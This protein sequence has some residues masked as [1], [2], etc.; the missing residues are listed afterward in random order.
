[1]NNIIIG[2]AGH[3]DHGKSSLIRALTGVETDRLAEEKK[4]GITI[5]LGFAWLDLP[6]GGRA[7]IIDVPGHERFISNMLAGAG[8]M[9]LAL[10]IVAADEGVMPQ[11]REHLEILSLLGVPQGIIVINKADLVDSEWLELVSE[12][13]RENCVGTF[14]ENAPLYQVSAQTGAGIEELREAIFQELSQIKEKNPDLPFRLPIDRAFAKDGFGLVV[15]GTCLEGRVQKGEELSLYPEA[16][17]LK[18]RS[19]QVHGREAELGQAGQ[20]LAINLVGEAKT[21]VSRGKCLA[22]LDSLIPTEYLE[23][24]VSVLPSSKYSIKTESRLHL[25]LGASE[26][27]CRI[28]LYGKK[29]LNPGET[30]VARLN[31]SE[32]IVAKYQ[33]PFVLRFYSPLSTIAGGQVLDPFPPKQSLSAKAR[34]EF[35]NAWQEASDKERLALA[36][37]S[38]SRHYYKLKTAVLRAGLDAVKETELAQLVAELSS[39]KR[40]Y[41]LSPNLYVSAAFLEKMGQSAQAIFAEYHQAQPLR[42]G[43]RREEARSRIAPKVGLEIQDGLLNALTELKYLKNIDKLVADYN[44]SPQRSPAVSAFESHILKAYEAAGFEPF[45][46]EEVEAK[47]ITDRNAAEF[48]ALKQE[49]TAKGQKESSNSEILDLLLEDLIEQ[50]ELIRLNSEL[51]ISATYYNQAKEIVRSTIEAEGALRLADFRDQIKSSRK[52]AV[53]ILE[54]MDKDKLTKLRGDLRFLI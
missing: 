35:L 9:D 45:V 52:Y 10:L 15:T 32:A 42:A 28:I 14:L 11:T 26:Q 3:V 17:K 53:A 51:L 5:E 31:L 20:R 18:V 36:I 34:V 38:Q 46:R 54:K 13:V 12:D 23:V 25:H 2:T 44:F 4:R 41:E 43:M 49:L 27:L 29:E 48:A 1:M 40:I 22:R 50:G 7:G 39:E 33:D 8:G 37:D 24:Q 16:A 21:Q 19:I 47:L 30:A 6:D